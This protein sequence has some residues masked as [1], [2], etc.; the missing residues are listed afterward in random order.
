[1]RR[2]LAEL[3]K[4]SRGFHASV[5]EV[6]ATAHPCQQQLRAWGNAIP[7]RFLPCA[8]VKEVSQWL[9]SHREHG[10]RAELCLRKG[11][12]RHAPDSAE[13]RH[14]VLQVPDEHLQTRGQAVLRSPRLEGPCAAHA[15]CAAALCMQLPRAHV[16]IL[17]VSCSPQTACS[18]GHPSSMAVYSRLCR[19]RRWPRRARRWRCPPQTPR[20][21]CGPPAPCPPP[22]PA[23]SKSP[24]VR[25]HK[26]ATAFHLSTVNCNTS[27]AGAR[28]GKCSD[29]P[30]LKD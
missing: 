30:V 14:M 9:K 23:A 18:T 21:L 27:I 10:L 24:A 2:K 15:I 22:S 19:G 13:R 28:W 26:P 12:G 20:C 17:Q 25:T 8:I 16:A 11:A 7:G 1:M 4:R 29:L 5:L 3:S 6:P